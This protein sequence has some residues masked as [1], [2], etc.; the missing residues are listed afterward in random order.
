MQYKQATMQKYKIQWWGLFYFRTSA[1]ITNPTASVFK[2]IAPTWFYRTAGRHSACKKR[3]C[4]AAM[5]QDHHLARFT[6]GTT[7]RNTCPQHCVI[8]ILEKKTQHKKHGKN[9]I[10]KLR[11]Y[12]TGIVRPIYR[13]PPLAGT[14]TDVPALN[15]WSSPP[16]HTQTTPAGQA[17]GSLRRAAVTL[18]PF[19]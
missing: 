6:R 19:N 8:S 5:T 13:C 11:Q 7:P 16:S 18:P 15:A 14:V 17:S 4:S 2:S 1:V 3:F 12:S 10:G 9:Y